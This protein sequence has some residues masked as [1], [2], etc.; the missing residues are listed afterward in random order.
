MIRYQP[1]APGLKRRTARPAYVRRQHGA[2]LVMALV[3][4]LILTILGVTAMRLS[5]QETIMS[6]NMQEMTKAF[7]AAE[8]GLNKAISETGSFDLFTP[9]TSNYTFAGGKSGSAT[10]VTTWL[11]NTPPKRGN[12]P[13]GNQTVEAANFEQVSTGSTLVNARSVVHQGVQLTIPKN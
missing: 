13:S 8:S 11:Q 7:E 4:L 9:K 10:V 2:I 12:K 1:I 5:S 6:G 3:F